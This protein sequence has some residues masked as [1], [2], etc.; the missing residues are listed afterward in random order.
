MDSQFSIYKIIMSSVQLENIAV[1]ITSYFRGWCR[2]LFLFLNLFPELLTECYRS[3][4]SSWSWSRMKLSG[5]TKRT[6]RSESSFLQAIGW[7]W[8]SEGRWFEQILECPIYY[9]LSYRVDRYMFWNIINFMVTECLT[10]E[11]NSMQSIK[12]A[13]LDGGTK[14]RDVHFSCSTF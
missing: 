8:H 1:C 12:I 2:S 7:V 3:W 6:Q 13:I 11:R 10:E 5:D 14:Y 9:R 4:Y